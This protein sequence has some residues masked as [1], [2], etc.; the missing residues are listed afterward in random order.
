VT[1][2]IAAAYPGNK[3]LVKLLVDNGANIEAKDK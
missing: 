3:G 2:L 1:T